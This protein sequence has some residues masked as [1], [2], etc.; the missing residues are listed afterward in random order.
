MSLKLTVDI[1]L[2]VQANLDAIRH[3]GVSLMKAIEFVQT[4]KAT[5][6]NS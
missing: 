1:N 3:V 4:E 6:N 2:I 5:T